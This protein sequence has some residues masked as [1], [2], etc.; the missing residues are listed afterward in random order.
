MKK[1]VIIRGV[2]IVG[3]AVAGYQLA[4]RREHHRRDGEADTER[5]PQAP[6]SNRNN[7]RNARTA[8]LRKQMATRIA[9]Q[10]AQRRA[11]RAGQ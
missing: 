10:G 7:V 1:T 11:A 6:R 9:A 8:A 5:R 4:R 3:S 2:G